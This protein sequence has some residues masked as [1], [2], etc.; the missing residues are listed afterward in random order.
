MTKEVQ[1]R[2]KELVPLDKESRTI[3]WDKGTPKY[4]IACEAKVFYVKNLREWCAFYEVN[5]HMLTRK[6][7]S[8][9][10]TFVTYKAI[11]VTKL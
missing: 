5:Y 4:K 7:R 3:A 11:E 1:D 2:I 8:T 6:I 9:A 10:E